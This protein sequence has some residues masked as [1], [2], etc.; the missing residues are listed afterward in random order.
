[1]NLEKPVHRLSRI[2]NEGY[3]LQSN[4]E[5]PKVLKGRP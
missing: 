4:S 2:K 3:R 1:M 5:G